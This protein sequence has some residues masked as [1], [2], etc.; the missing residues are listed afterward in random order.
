MLSI[1]D[2][3]S[4]HAERQLGMIGPK[5]M[6]VAECVRPDVNR[7]R[8]VP[9]KAHLSHVLEPPLPR[10]AV[11]RIGAARLLDLSVGTFD[12]W[13]RHEMVGPEVSVVE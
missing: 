12:N 6:A 4:S 3:L 5:V 7:S 13:V 8:A 10:L 11:S 1:E 9:M 2:V